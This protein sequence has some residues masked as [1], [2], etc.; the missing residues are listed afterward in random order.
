[1][2]TERD[3][4][5][6]AFVILMWFYIGQSLDRRRET[7]QS[8]E[9][10]ARSRPLAIATAALYLALGCFLVYRVFTSTLS[11]ETWFIAIVVVWAGVLVGTS[12]WTFRRG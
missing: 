3:W 10:P 12:V 11:M 8:I 4:W 1:M 9:P 7:V 2:E 6:L 5:Y